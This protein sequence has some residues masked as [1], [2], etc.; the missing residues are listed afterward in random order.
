MLYPSDTRLQRI[1]DI[2]TAVVKLI[3][4]EGV[5]AVTMRRVA[6]ANR[7]SLGSLTAHVSTRDRLVS[8]CV[9]NLGARRRARFE[10][11]FALEGWPAFL[12]ADSTDLWY[13][14]T[15]LG[16]R[17]WARA[18]EGLHML[19]LQ[20]EL[21]ERRALQR[22]VLPASRVPGDRAEQEVL[23][24]RCSA[25]WAAIWGF[26]EQL[27]G[28]VHEDLDTSVAHAALGALLMPTDARAKPEAE[29]DSLTP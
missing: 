15:W 28:N 11:R 4:T 2:T 18:S 14:R 3:C 19:M 29:G 27:C 24:L 17:E 12:P 16:F 5:G 9:D 10:Q 8:A 25:A 21:P 20:W 1:D 6:E 7:M 23:R 13:E 26:R 22:V